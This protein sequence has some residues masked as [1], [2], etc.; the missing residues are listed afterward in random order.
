VDVFDAGFNLVASFTDPSLPAGYAPFGI[1]NVGGKLFVTFA[2]VGADGDDEPGVG[3][4][5]V[6]VFN[7]DGT[8][9]MHFASNGRLNSPWGIAVAPSG[10]GPFAGAILIG[11]FGDGFIGAY[12]AST[13]A[14]IDMLHDANGA[15]IAIDGLWGLDFGPGAA[16]TSLYFAAG[17]NDETHGTIGILTPK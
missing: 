9:S 5:F 4:G 6:D 16:S 3:N 12:N 8:L 11:N 17:L 13:G 14:F 7:G 1:R 15:E 10:F 2:K